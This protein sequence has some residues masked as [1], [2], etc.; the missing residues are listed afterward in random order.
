MVSTNPFENHPEVSIATGSLFFKPSMK[1][2]LFSRDPYFMVCEI[3][4]TY[5]R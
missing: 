3:I 2:W 4:P 5:N 1:Y